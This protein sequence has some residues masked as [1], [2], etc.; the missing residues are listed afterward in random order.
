VG[1]AGA[2]GLALSLVSEVP[3]KV[4]FCTAKN[5][6]PWEKPTADNTKTTVQGGHTI[7]L[8]EGAALREVERRLN[9]GVDVLSMDMTLAAAVADRL[10]GGGKKERKKGCGH[11]EAVLIEASTVEEVQRRLEAVAPSVRALAAL[12]REAQASFFQ[13]QQKWNRT[14][15][16]RE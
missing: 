13:L 7:W 5:I 2:P 11:Q 9:R 15:A 16:G 14:V 6:R 1:R 12:E 10:A 3:E 8:D 4:W